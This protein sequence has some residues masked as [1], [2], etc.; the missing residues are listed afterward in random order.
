LSLLQL[1]DLKVELPIEGVHKT[2]LRG[3]SLA[4]DEG[5]ALGLVG[6]SGAGKS[7]T[8][9]AIARL[10]PANARV[11][12][13]ISFDDHSVLEL[14]R[15]VLRTLRGSEIGMIFQDPRA[16]I[17]PM[18]RVG[19]FMVEGL[20]DTK[21]VPRADAER[22]AVAQ[23]EAVRIADP[24]RC[25]R[26]YPHQLSGGMLQRVMIASTLMM[27]PRLILADEPTTALDVTTQAEVVAILDALR[28]ERG[29]AMLFI[30]HDLELARAVTHRTAVMYAGEIVEVQ[31]SDRLHSHPLHPYTAA[32][33]A[34][35]PSIDQTVTRLP[36][37]T[38]R[39]IPAFEAPPGCSF[40][41]RC[42]HAVE[43]CLQDPPWEEFQ[44]GCTRCWR[45]AELREHLMSKAAG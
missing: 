41:P 24:E 5:E 31:P 27:D 23:L 44:E 15:N 28:R 37:I 38:G 32:L 34:S 3:V 14:S 19:A 10:L 18:R 22:R 43:V 12:G 17:N 2:V 40:A 33:V 21:G 26:S 45:S 25:L 16:A 29:L 9:R 11:S 35:R 36:S 20:C 39:A 6:E 4:V 13:R 7:M 42:P 1:E 8:A 30:S